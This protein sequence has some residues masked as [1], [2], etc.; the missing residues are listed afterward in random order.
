MGLQSSILK[1]IRGEKKA[2][3]A[4]A[5]L[6]GLSGIYRFAIAIRNFSYDKKLLSS[7]KLSVPVISVGNLVAGGTGKTPLIHLLALALQEKTRLGILSRGYKSQIERS[8]QI[9]QVSTALDSAGVYGD[10]PYFLAQKTKA[11]IWVGAD[12]LASGK[13]AV[14][15]GVTCLLLDDGMQHR[16]L[17]RD[18]E[19]VVVDGVNPFS[20]GKFLPCGLLRD[21]P[22]RLKNADLIVAT[23]VKDA[24]DF[25]QIQA[26]ISPFT[27]A[28]LVAVQIEVLNKNR[29]VPR[30][31]GVFCGIGQPSRFLQTT[32]DLNQEIVDTLFLNDHASLPDE[33]LERFAKKCLEKGAEVLLCTEKDY[34]KLSRKMFSLEIVPV[35]IGLK[36]IHGRK[37]WEKLIDNIL[38]KAIK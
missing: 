23:H 11:S 17:F 37:H 35:E 12:R 32:R 6:F 16:R 22:K 4:K 30:K 19:V 5:C 7:A 34:V 1:I 15:K 20:E 29:L 33:Q 24:T 25:E 27:D 3:I 8:G 26:L 28:P 10:E 38:D 9:K 13:Q 18:F 21:S 36:I 2:P 31:V 14:E